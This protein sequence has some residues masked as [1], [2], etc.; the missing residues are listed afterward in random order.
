MTESTTHPSPKLA[1]LVLTTGD[2]D[3]PLSH[4][5]DAEILR[6]LPGEQIPVDGV[7]LAGI[8][9]VDESMLAGRSIPVK[10]RSGSMVVRATINLTGSLVMRVERL[11]ANAWLS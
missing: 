9:L 8:S 2:V 11:R 6:V 10:K 1:H 3:V 4:V 7:V 5:K